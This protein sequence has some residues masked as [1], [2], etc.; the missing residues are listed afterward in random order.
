MINHQFTCFVNGQ[1]KGTVPLDSYPEL[2]LF[3]A[4]IGAT[5]GSQSNFQL[6]E[7]KIWNHALSASEILE[8]YKIAATTKMVT[9]QYKNIF[10]E[11]AAP[12]EIHRK[13]QGADFQLN[14]S[15]TYTGKQIIGATITG[16]Q[17]KTVSF[18]GDV[19]PENWAK[20]IT[21]TYED[22][23]CRRFDG[24]YGISRS[25]CEALVDLYKNLDGANWANQQ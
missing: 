1:A 22:T 6:D 4:N 15:Y 9:I 8:E 7:L 18:T 16:E 19:P 24:K 17:S 11:T 23:Y 14:Q 13:Y 5:N 25:E 3:Q 2:G 21:F 10:G 12:Q 20:E